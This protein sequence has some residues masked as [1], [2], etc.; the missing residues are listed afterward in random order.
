ML[1]LDIPPSSTF[2]GFASTTLL[3]VVTDIV[4]H[5][6]LHVEKSLGNGRRRNVD[7][8]IFPC[9]H[10]AAT[11]TAVTTLCL[12]RKVP[13]HYLFSV[14]HSLQTCLP[15]PKQNIEGYS[16]LGI[17]FYSATYSRYILTERKKCRLK[18]G[19]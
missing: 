18:G 8:C 4:L 10:H 5:S 12:P 7:M 19:R 17:D 13:T 16:F 14:T 15:N 1:F 3:H 11:Y 2:L 9:R 6:R